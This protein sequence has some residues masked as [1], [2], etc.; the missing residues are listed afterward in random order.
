MKRL[1]LYSIL[2]FAFA[3]SA[4]A[5][6]TINFNSGFANNGD[7]PDNDLNGW[8]DTRN[9]NLTEYN[10]FT[11]TDVQVTLNISGGWNGD[12]YGY[13]V[14]DSGFAV[15]L[16]RVGRTGNPG[17]TF[18]YGEAGFTGVTLVDGLSLTSIQNYGGS[19]TA[20][21]ALDGGS[22]SSAGGTLNSSFD[23]LNVNGNWT[24]FLADMS[25][26]DMSQITGWT[27]SITAVPEPTTWAML[28]FGAAFGC[29]H[30][31]RWR[32]KRA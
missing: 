27:L 31:T 26:G 7:I 29:W 1:T 16:D 19:Y 9:L 4:S 15:L 28:I 20:T 23:G 13:L 18:G 21:T 30:L 11:V 24:L 3:L 2:L 12:L 14:H 32:M 22:Y 17:E 5:S 25:S 6:L 10:G 8:S